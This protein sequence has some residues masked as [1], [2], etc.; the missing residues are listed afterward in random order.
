MYSFLMTVTLQIL[1]FLSQ[2]T[3]PYFVVIFK[4]IAEKRGDSLTILQ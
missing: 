2:N 1:L 3:I 4:T